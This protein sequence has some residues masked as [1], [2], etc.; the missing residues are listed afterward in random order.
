[1]SEAEAAIGH[2]STAAELTEDQKRALAF[3]H[4]G[5]YSRALAEK[6][7][8]DAK[9]KNMCK[10]I[11]AEGTAIDDIKSMLS[12]EKDGGEEVLR[13]DI[14]RMMKVAR[15]MGAHIGEQFDLEEAIADR[16]TVDERQFT[17]GKLAG[18]RGETCVAPYTGPGGQHWTRGWHEGQA[19]LVSALELTKARAATEEPADGDSEEQAVQEPEA[20]PTP[21]RKR[22]RP[23]KQAQNGSGPHAG[24]VAAQTAAELAEPIDEIDT[25]F[26]ERH[27]AEKDRD[28][29]EF[30]NGGAPAFNG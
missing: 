16:R 19:A 11:I 22:G 3:H 25:P 2:N 29:A 17:E 28:A 20:A 27:R 12:L 9:F 5:Q 4:K 6:K 24:A 7:E 15:W 10:S 21:P 18:M 30:E 26:A 23:R 1:M 14:E 13:A 8:A